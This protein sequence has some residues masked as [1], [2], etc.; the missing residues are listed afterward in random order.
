MFRA[1]IPFLPIS[2][3][4]SPAAIADLLVKTCPTHV[5]VSAD[6]SMHKLLDESLALLT[7]ATRPAI[8]A[9]PV[10]NDIYSEK[11]KDFQPLPTRPHNIN[12]SSIIVHS[13]GLICDMNVVFCLLLCLIQALPLFLNPSAGMTEHVVKDQWHLV[14]LFFL[15]LTFCLK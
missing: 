13:S 3:R 10:Y 9:M 2:P 1:G 4:N 12:V 7:E 6:E 15:Q 14:C 8:G 11:E 5:L